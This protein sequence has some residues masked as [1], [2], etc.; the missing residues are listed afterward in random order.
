MLNQKNGIILTAARVDNGLAQ[1]FGDVPPALIPVNGRPLI[2]HQIENFINF[3]VKHICISVGFKKEKVINLVSNYYKDRVQLN[4]IEVDYNLPPGNSLIDCLS[5]IPS[6]DVIINLGDTFLPFSEFQESKNTL[7]VSANINQTIRWS[8]LSVSEKGEISFFEKKE[9]G[10]FALIGIYQITEFNSNLLKFSKSKEYEITE[11]LEGIQIDFSVL[12]ERGWLDFG[13]I[14]KYQSSKKRLLESRDFNSLEFN[15]LFGTITKRSRNVN[16]FKNEISWQLNVPNDLKILSPRIV[17]YSLS[18]KPFVE[19]EYYSYPTISE[20]WLYSSFDESILK[21]VVEKTYTILLCFLNKKE[22][23]S[24]SS[25]HHIYSEKTE[26][27]I[28]ELVLEKSFIASLLKL[29]ELEINGVILKGWPHLKQKIDRLIPS[30]YN[31]DHNCFIHGDFC[32]S[33]IL[34][35]V[36]SGIVRI[37]DPRGKWG[38]TMNGDIKYDIAKLRHSINGDYDF[39]V[40]DLFEVRVEKSKINYSV[41]TSKKHNKIKKYFDDLV[42]KDFDVQQINLIEGLLFLSMIPLHKNNQRRQLMM[43]SKAIENLNSL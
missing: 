36:N 1:L 32:F 4:F 39:I 2:F 11:V 31:K 28:N 17:N 30:L 19:M 37:I 3:G 20:L 9:H 26:K 33:N 21:K 12:K 38:E 34:F 42:R 16:K 8:K 13:H 6:G 10:D 23:V 24:K 22:E 29:D 15:D 35:D 41:Y 25:Y 18:D 14:D 5:K 27:R 43:F 7:F 40:Q